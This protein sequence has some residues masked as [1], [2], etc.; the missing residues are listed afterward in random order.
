M[1]KDRTIKT[2]ARQH[3]RCRG[4]GDNTQ[5]RW[6]GGGR[7]I[8]ARKRRGRG[9]GGGCREG[10]SGSEFR[11]GGEKRLGWSAGSSQR[12]LRSMS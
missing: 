10:G 7:E 4:P 11:V 12:V 1:G 2:S 5:E 8:E 3:K 9:E 6:G